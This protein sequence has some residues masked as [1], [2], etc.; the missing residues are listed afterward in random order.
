MKNNNEIH[1]SDLVKCLKNS[2]IKLEPAFLVKLLKEASK[3]DFPTQN[4]DFALTIGCPFNDNFQTS[5]TIRS[6]TRDIISTLRKERTF[7]D[8]IIQLVLPQ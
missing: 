8:I 2:Y 6:W 4:K 3:C 1:L 5:P 7:L